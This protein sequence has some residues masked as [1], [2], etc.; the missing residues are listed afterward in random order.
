[1]ESTLGHR[2]FFRFYEEILKQEIYESELPY[3]SSDIF[4]TDEQIAHLKD[5]I[6]S[7]VS[8]TKTQGDIFAMLMEEMDTYLKGGKDLDSSCEILQ[9]RAELYFKEKK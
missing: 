2:Q 5:M 8:N 4:F 3:L 1:M 9:N 6:N 7:A